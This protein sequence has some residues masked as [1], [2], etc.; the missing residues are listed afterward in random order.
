MNIPSLPKAR[1]QFG[2]HWLH[3]QIVLDQIVT[4]AELKNGDPGAI[5]S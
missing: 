5:A 2:Q 4:S 1:K 3:D